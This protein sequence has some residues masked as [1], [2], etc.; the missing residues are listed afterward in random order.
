MPKFMSSGRRM[1]WL[2]C[3][4]WERL[5][6]ICM[7][8]TTTA[9]LQNKIAKVTNNQ[10]LSVLMQGTLAFWSQT[11]QLNCIVTYSHKNKMRSTNCTPAKHTHSIWEHWQWFG[12][13][14]IRGLH[15]NQNTFTIEE[16]TNFTKPFLAPISYLGSLWGRTSGRRLL[17]VRVQAQNFESQGALQCERDD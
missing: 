6:T 12:N 14:N 2:S 13:A 15:E 4:A 9:T 7:M 16:K 5:C 10:S 3:W 1:P 17:S 8:G 11:N